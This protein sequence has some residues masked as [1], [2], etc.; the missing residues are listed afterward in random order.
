MAAAAAAVEDNW[1]GTEDCTATE[2]EMAANKGPVSRESACKSAA[3]ALGRSA[4]S[5]DTE[6]AGPEL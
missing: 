5:A 6:T 3:Q 2:R 1:C 4:L